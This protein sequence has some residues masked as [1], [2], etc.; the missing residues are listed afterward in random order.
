M[1]GSFRQYRGPRDRDALISY[2]E[3][4]RWKETEPIP[5]W[6]APGSAQMSAVAWY[7]KL[8]QVLRTLHSQ[9]MDHYGLPVWGSYLIFAVA[10]ILVGALLGLVSQQYWTLKEQN[11]DLHLPHFLI[12]PIKLLGNLAFLLGF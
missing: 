12:L 5:S 10:T 1:E 6:K 8:S 3:D 9:L 4:K 11:P 2:V 7:F